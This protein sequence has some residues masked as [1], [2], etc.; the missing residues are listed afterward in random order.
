MEVKRFWANEREKERKGKKKKMRDMMYPRLSLEMSQPLK[1][2]FLVDHQSPLE[3]Q[4]PL[5]P[6]LRRSSRKREGLRDDPM[7]ARMNF[8][9]HF[10]ACSLVRSCK[11]C[12][13]R[14][15]PFDFLLTRLFEEGLCKM[16]INLKA[17]C[18]K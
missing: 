2:S 14:F 9:Y 16:S 15:R 8:L 4:S 13:R 10:L 17:T 5:Q 12:L 6:L 1:T 18:I 11:P 3:K 7:F